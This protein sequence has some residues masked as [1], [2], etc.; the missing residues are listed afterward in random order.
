M[1]KNNLHLLK[2]C[3]KKIS[4]LKLKCHSSNFISVPNNEVLKLAN[5]DS[6]VLK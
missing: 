2:I 6:T 1:F 4:N 3:F 5:I